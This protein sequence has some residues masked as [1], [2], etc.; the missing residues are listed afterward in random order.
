[1]GDHIGIQTWDQ[2]NL[3]QCFYGVALGQASHLLG[4]YQTLDNSCK[5]PETILG[6]A[7]ID[8]SSLLEIHSYL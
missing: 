7:R 5:T 8:K 6:L 3:N 2:L 4:E 1:M